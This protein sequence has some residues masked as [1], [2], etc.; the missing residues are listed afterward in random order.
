MGIAVLDGDALVYHGV[1]TTSSSLTPHDRLDA[2]RRIV[3]RLIRD[4][5]PDIL[6]I[7]K[8]FF[9]RSRNAAL[10]NV[11]ADEIQA[12]A[13]NKGIPV[14]AV[15]PSTV[16]KRIAG[17]GNATKRAVAN[18]VIVRY[19]ELN[20]YR[21]Q[22]RKWKERFHGNMFDAVAIGLAAKEVDRRKTV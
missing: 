17:N 5:R 20:V 10:L 12:I 18:A 19:P 3:L 14:R 7:E 11:L 9:A 15:A 21:G 4:F 13:R 16:K 2:G 6:A 22:D 1:K 8:T